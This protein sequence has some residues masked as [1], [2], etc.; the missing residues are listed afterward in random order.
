MAKQGMTVVDLW[1]AVCADAIYEV[2]PATRRKG[3]FTGSVRPSEQL[4]VRRSW[5]RCAERTGEDE[6]GRFEEAGGAKYAG[7]SA[8]LYLHQLLV[9]AQ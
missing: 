5:G 7:G 8:P 4:A 2:D 3:D 9:D 6:C 1:V